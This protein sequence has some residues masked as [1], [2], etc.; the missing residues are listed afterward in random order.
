MIVVTI[1]TIMSACALCITCGYRVY[2]LSN[3]GIAIQN[4]YAFLFG[5]DPASG[6]IT[7]QAINVRPRPRQVLK[8]GLGPSQTR[9]L[10]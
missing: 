6:S 2:D 8:P 5:V 3:Y 1:V 10:M 7:D 4:T 9:P